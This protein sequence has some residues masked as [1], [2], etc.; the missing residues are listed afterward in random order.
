MKTESWV[1]WLA[2]VLF[3]AAGYLL[4]GAIAWSFDPGQWGWFTRACIFTWM[5]YFTYHIY[6][7]E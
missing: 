4:G 1:K 6:A 5:A 2:W 3:M 7:A